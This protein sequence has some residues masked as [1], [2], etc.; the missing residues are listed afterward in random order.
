MPLTKDEAISQGFKWKED[1]P[2]TY[3]KGTI[4]MVDLPDSINNITDNIINEIFTC[5]RTGK[6]FN[7][8]KQEL[9]L[10]RKLNIPLPRLHYDERYKDRMR[11]RPERRLYDAICAISGKNIKTTYPP[12]RR[13]KN[14]VSDEVYKKEVL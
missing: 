5:E 9:D 14:I 6:N 4:N 3:G 7:I 13:P 8:T 10:C 1:L 12:H 2:G 11:I